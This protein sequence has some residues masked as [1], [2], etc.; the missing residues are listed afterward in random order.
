MALQ[1]SIETRSDESRMHSVHNDLGDALDVFNALIN[2]RDWSDADRCVCL[3]DTDKDQRMAVY[4]L[5][6]FNYLSNNGHETIF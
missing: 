2:Q 6:D 5:Q 4:G 3:M 1:I